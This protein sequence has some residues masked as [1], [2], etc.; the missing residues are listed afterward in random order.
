MTRPWA[1][2]LFGVVSGVLLGFWLSQTGPTSALR[3]N[4]QA[5]LIEGYGLIV[6][7]NHAWADGQ[8]HSAAVWINEGIAYLSASNGDLDAVGVHGA[9]SMAIYVNR[10][11]YDL[12]SHKESQSQSRVIST[13][14]GAFKPFTRTNFGSI[15]D[16]QL[17][18]AIDRIDA[19]IRSR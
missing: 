3:T 19:A 9:S 4:G 16:G 15:P 2:G 8:S 17:Q 12:M 6:Q 5:N 10:A 18:A 1:M 7:G 14:T 13:F 11:E